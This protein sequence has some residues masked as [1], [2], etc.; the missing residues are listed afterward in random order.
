MNPKSLDLV[1][2]SFEEKA[3]AQRKKRPA[4]VPAVVF[5]GA[6]DIHTPRVLCKEIL[7][8][9][10]LSNKSILVLFNIEFVLGL[11]GDFGVEASNITLYSDH[12]TKTRY[13]TIMGVNIVTELEPSMKFDVIVGNPPYQSGNGE[14]GGRHS[15][16]RT[17]V[18]KSFSLVEKNG[19]VGFVCPGF[20]FRANDLSKCFFDNTPIVLV[21]DATKYFPGVGSE[22][23]YWIVQQGKH[24]LPFIVDGIHWVNGLNDDPTVNPMVIA[25][26]KKL[27]NLP[28]FECKHDTGYSSTQYKND[29]TDY[30]DAPTGTSVYPI[31]HASTVKICYVSKPTECHY[32]NKVM[33][34]FSG[35]PDYEY[36]D[37]TTSPI[38]SCYQMSGYIE[39][40]NQI[41]GQRL[42][43]LYKTKL[44]T[45]LSRLDGAGIKGINSYSLPKVDLSKEWDDEKLY[46]Q[47]NLTQEEIDYIEANAK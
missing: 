3:D 41:E 18:K 47:F 32:K 5:S 9:L 35:Y 31:R 45:F 33:M 7:D 26:R 44:Y 8:N 22:I 42:I 21:N 15:L 34:T 13:A 37:G 38:S 28:L 20:P 4:P 17:L 24:N 6:H 1:W 14:K 30:F 12:P 40:A 46:K 27:A 10:E 43:A 29:N 25:I 23:K 16:W 11:I 39:V 19:F 36:F 2:R